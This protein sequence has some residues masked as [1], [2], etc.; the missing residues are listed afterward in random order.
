M[1]VKTFIK[2]GILFVIMS[3]AAMA[4]LPSQALECSIT[5]R[6]YFITNRTRIEQSGIPSTQKFRIEFPSRDQALIYNADNPKYPIRKNLSISNSTYRLFGIFD[7]EPEFVSRSSYF[8]HI[9]R[10]TGAVSGE[11]RTNHL[12]GLESLTDMVGECD[13]RSKQPKF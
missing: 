5:F 4:Q 13:L 6:E 9:D 2:S 3:D 8:L 12:G 11:S 1:L 10:F 7:M